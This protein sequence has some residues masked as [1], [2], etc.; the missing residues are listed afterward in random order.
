MNNKK[1][2]FYA[3]VSVLGTV[4]LVICFVVMFVM[5]GAIFKDTMGTLFTEVR[6]IGNITEN[7]NVTSLANHVFNPVE[8]IMNNYALYASMLYI[9]GI[10]LIFT[11][12]F[13]F[14]D[15]VNL[16]TVSLFFVAAILIVLFAIILSNTY[17]EF[18]NGTDFMGT[19]L[20]DAT[21]ASYLILYCPTILSIVIFLAGII[22]FSGK[23]GGNP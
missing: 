15:N 12:A 23:E 5:G 20:R 9:F 6:G 1:G 4:L 17:E 14:R 8:T 13:I 18:Y 7:V 2:N 3:T 21:T 10:I 16:L 19:E 11:L 22:L